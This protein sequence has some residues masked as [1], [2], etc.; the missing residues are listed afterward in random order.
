MGVA[1]PTSDD[2][3]GFLKLQTPPS[4]QAMAGYEEA[5]T[6]ALDDIESRIS[7]AFVAADGFSLDQADNNYPPR[8]RLA[9]LMDAARLAKRAT[10]PE[11]VAG[12][13]ELG[14]SVRILSNDP[15]IERLI[16]RFLKLDGFS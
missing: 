15:D 2:L 14:I 13:S 8:V 1:R 16:R 11:G 3:V 7:A 6:G 5:M 12:M 9:V 10:S 4:E